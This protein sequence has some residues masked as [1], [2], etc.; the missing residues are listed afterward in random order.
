[1]GL[2]SSTDELLVGQGT[3]QRQDDGKRADRRW[4]VDGWI[5]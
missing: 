5:M 3:Q 4:M 1:M 2:P